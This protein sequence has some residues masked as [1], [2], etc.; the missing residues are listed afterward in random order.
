M[1]AR[2]EDIGGALVVDG[3]RQG[4]AMGGTPEIDCKESGSTL[5]FLIPVAL[6]M[7][8]GARL[9]GQGNLGKRRWMYIPRYSM[10]RGLRTKRRARCWI[11]K[12]P[13]SC[14]QAHFPCGG[15]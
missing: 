11:S 4:Q 2:I 8:H 10:S 15:M 9:I 3:I 14:A 12:Y 7:A 1:G 13:D 5:R 6:K